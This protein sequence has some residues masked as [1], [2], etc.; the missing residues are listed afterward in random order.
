MKKSRIFAALLLTGFILTSCAPTKAVRGNLVEEFQEKEIQA[1][2]STRADVA[3]VL[4]S[5]TTQAPFDENI[6]YY[7]G[8]KTEKT[9]IFDPKVVEE[10]IVTVTFNEQ[11]IVETVKVSGNNRENIP[12]SQRKTPS[13]GSSVTAVQQFL[14]NLGKYNQKKAS[15]TAIGKGTPN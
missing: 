1:G 10:K 5:P 2:V 7:L 14:G 13:G 12:I 9:G 8:Q 11:G 4:G 3:R 15:P 6:W